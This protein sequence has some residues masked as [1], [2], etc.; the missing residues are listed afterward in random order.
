MLQAFGILW[1]VVECG[2]FFSVRFSEGVSNY[3]WLF[4]M[5]GIIAGFFRAWPRLSV[6]S[7]VAGTDCSITIRVCD[8]FAV[9]NVAY[10][11]ST[12]TTFDTAMDDGTIDV[13]SVQGQLTTRLYGSREQLDRDIVHSLEGV[14]FTEVTREE[15]PYGELQRYEI[16]TVASI[17]VERTRSYLVAIAAMN[18]HRVA[19][20]TRR[21]VQDAL[22]CLWEYLRMRGGREK[23][24][25]PILGAGY[26]RVDA[27]REALIHELIRSFIP[28]IKAGAFCEGL[29]IAI[30][31]QDFSEGRMELGR[32]DQF[33]QHEC[34]YGS[35][36]LGA[37]NLPATGTAQG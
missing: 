22:P 19:Q 33:L 8:L 32:L 12:N 15:K 11:V 14:P 25:C 37:A 6:S 31:P 28:A 21:D 7:F 3:W 35:S 24:C 9:D 1:L 16:G 30:S 17:Q 23:L 36:A 27:T 26:S 29:T 34:L 13:D 18:A 2:A 10:V 5:I 4:L 20:A